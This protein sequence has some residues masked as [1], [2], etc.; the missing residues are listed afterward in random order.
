MTVSTLGGG[1]L[2]WVTHDATSLSRSEGLA[3]GVYTYPQIPPASGSMVY[4]LQLGSVAGSKSKANN[5]IFRL[6]ALLRFL[7]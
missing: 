4:G 1:V 3:C 6:C 2:G 7:L 5:T